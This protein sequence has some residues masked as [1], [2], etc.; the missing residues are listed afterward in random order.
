MI[1]LGEQLTSGL[2]LGLLFV[3]GGIYITNHRRR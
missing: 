3:S 1:V 2:V